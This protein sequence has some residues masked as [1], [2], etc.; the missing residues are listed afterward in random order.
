M[1]SPATSSSV[2]RPRAGRF[3]RPWIL[4]GVV[5]GLVAVGGGGAVLLTLASFGMV[6]G[7][8]FCPDQFQRRSFVFYQVPLLRVQVT[9]VFRDEQSHLLSDYL[10]K[11]GLLPQPTGLATKWD[12]MQTFGAASGHWKGNALILCN[13]LD[14]QNGDGSYRWLTWSKDHPQLAKSLWP[15]IAE[16]ARLQLY[17][18]TPGLF[19]LADAADG[20]NQ[21]NERISDYLA[22]GYCWLADTHHRLEKYEEAIGFYTLALAERADYRDALLGRA[23]SH[24]VLGNRG[25]ANRDLRHLREMTERANP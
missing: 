22:H 7:E 2:G 11:N 18:L 3:S 1:S 15:R 23:R 25:K 12:V 17:T 4:R 9:P 24:A 21:F 20:P 13:Y 6:T 8:E 10:T 5:I 16:V 19:A 14:Q